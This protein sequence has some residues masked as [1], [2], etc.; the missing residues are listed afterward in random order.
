MMLDERFWSKVTKTPGCWLWRAGKDRDGYGLFR[1]DGKQKRAHRL[2]YAV[3][4]GPPGKALVCHK[5]DNPPCVRPTHLFL[6]TNGDNIRDAVAKGR[7]EFQK[8]PSAA[9]KRAG[10]GEA[11]GRA[12]LTCKSVREIRRRLMAGETTVS[13][14][15]EYRVSQVLVSLIKRDRIWRNCRNEGL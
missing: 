13:L 7:M 11:N 12:K 9:S 1:F 10:C 14:G 15:K 5:C 2:A 3:L 8:D 4:V 6:G